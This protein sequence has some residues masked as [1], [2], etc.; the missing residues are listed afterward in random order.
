MENVKVD[1]SRVRVVDLEYYVYG[2]GVEHTDSQSKVILVDFLGNDSFV[3]PFCLGDKYPIFKRVP[4]SNVTRDGES[5]GTKVCHIFGE[6]STGPCLIF[7]AVD[8]REA[9]GKDEV[10]LED[11]EAYVLDSLDFFK[12]RMSIV[13][14]RIRRG[15]DV[16][17]PS[18]K[19]MKDIAAM[20]AMDR[21]FSERE[22]TVQKVKKTR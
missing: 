19:M 22:C 9:V 11:I 20:D 18:A 3:N 1:S 8:F 2:R 5:Y 15:K 7:T 14:D 21:F 12:D 4:I 13:E 10:S 6:L 16:S 17:W